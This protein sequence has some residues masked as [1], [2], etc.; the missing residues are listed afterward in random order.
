M[1]GEDSWPPAVEFYDFLKIMDMQEPGSTQQQRPKEEEE[2]QEEVNEEE[3][4]VEDEATDSSSSSSA[5]DAN[6]NIHS[7]L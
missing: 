7:E 4:N 1:L 2:E 3:V 5:P 6:P